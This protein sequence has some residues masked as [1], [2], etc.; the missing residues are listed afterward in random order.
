MSLK[1]EVYGSLLFVES[2]SGVWSRNVKSVQTRS[3]NGA[4]ALGTD[5]AVHISRTWQKGDHRLVVLCA[6]AFEML[7][8]SM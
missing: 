8:F 4:K 3:G 7:G 2:A 6:C 1:F 5:R